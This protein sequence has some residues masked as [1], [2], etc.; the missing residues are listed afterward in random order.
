MPPFDDPNDPNDNGDY[1]EYETFSDYDDDD[2]DDDPF[3]PCEN[4]CVMCGRERPLNSEGYCSP[5]WTIWN[6]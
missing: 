2:Y 1:A 3:E 4:E 6:S 5:C